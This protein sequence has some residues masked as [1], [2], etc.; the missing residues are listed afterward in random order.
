[1]QKISTTIGHKMK[2][3]EQDTFAN[4]QATSS[5][6]RNSVAF[7]KHA[8]KS[9]RPILVSTQLR[10]EKKKIKGVQ[11]HVMKRV[12]FRI[13]KAKKQHSFAPVDGSA[14]EI[15]MWL[16]AVLVPLA[17]EIWAF[18]FRLAFCDIVLGNALF[19]YHVDVACDVMFVFDM[20]GV[21]VISCFQA[22]L[23][24]LAPAISCSPFKILC[25]S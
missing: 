23:L 20:I 1:M 8:G 25:D 12:H 7:S 9:L 14:R 4:H 6:Y 22:A 24:L 11:G 16:T 17:W 10:A 15:Q 5:P 3:S 21:H 13:P 18:P 19:V 2:N